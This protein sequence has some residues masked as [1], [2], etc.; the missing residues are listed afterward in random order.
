VR[1]WV[2][3]DRLGVGS[4]VHDP[5]VSLAPAAASGAAGALAVD[6]SARGCRRRPVLRDVGLI[7]S[8]SAFR[9]DPS[10]SCHAVSFAQ[11]G[12]DIGHLG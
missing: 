7:R 3:A 2:I 6:L 5:K 9:R 4:D 11:A 8:L 10:Q 1:S 12:T